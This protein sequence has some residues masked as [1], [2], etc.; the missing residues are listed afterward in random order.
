MEGMF[1][2]KVQR[3]REDFARVAMERARWK[4]C[5]L[6]WLLNTSTSCVQS[7][8][9]ESAME[10]M[11]THTRPDLRWSDTKLQWRERDGR[12]VHTSPQTPLYRTCLRC[13]G[14]S[15]M[16][17]MFTGRVAMPAIGTSTLQCRERDGA[18]I[19]RGT[20]S[21][22]IKQSLSQVSPDAV[23]QWGR[24]CCSTAKMDY[25]LNGR[26]EAFASIFR[27]C[28]ILGDQPCLNEA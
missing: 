5:S 7:C 1:T 15:A 17:G 16:E 23:M 26:G 3:Q 9:G 28:N 27:Y 6:S 24:G 22:H 14:E 19:A 10:G 8:N 11:F 25:R 20:C 18:R 21:I 12:D 2:L 4:G 13:N